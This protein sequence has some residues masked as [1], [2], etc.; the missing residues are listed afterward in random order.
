ML[1]TTRCILV[2]PQQA[3]VESVINLQENPEVRKYL[4]GPLKREEIIKR[5]EK[6]MAASKD[7]VYLI[8][9][10]KESFE[11]IGLLSLDT[12]HDGKSKELSYQ[13]LPKWWGS[14]YGSETIKRVMTYA[15]NELKITRLV[16]ETQSANIASCR[17][18]E[19]LG[20]TIKEK[21]ERFGAEQIIYEIS[22]TD[23]YE[24]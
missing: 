6:L 9:K 24:F 2:K 7:E 14:G 10:E 13:L 18:L 1:Q 19:G 22:I 8:I 11:F 3:D 5:Y 21:I 16:A 23:N 15:Y 17:L 20:M 12:H 4:G